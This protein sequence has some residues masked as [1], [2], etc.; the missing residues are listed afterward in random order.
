MKEEL[1]AKTSELKIARY[2]TKNVSM[3]IEESKADLVR[4]IG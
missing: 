2:E 4:L 1:S 3:L